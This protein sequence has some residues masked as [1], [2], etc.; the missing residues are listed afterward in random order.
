MKNIE[1]DPFEYYF[2]VTDRDKELQKLEEA[3]K[4]ADK[5]EEISYHC[6]KFPQCSRGFRRGIKQ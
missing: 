5:S 2:K 6:T 3:Q 1:D 4:K